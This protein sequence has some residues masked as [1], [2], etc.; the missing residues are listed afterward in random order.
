MRLKLT[1]LER[2]EAVWGKIKEAA[3]REIE[4]LRRKNEAVTLDPVQTA[5]IR[6]RI[7]QLRDLLAIG[8]DVNPSD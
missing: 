2:A 6:G 7:A 5:V 3:E 4:T 1:Q 8:E